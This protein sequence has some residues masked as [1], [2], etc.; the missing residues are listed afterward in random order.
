MAGL[1]R[2]SRNM[3]C[4]ICGGDSWCFKPAD[5]PHAIVCMRYAMGG[6]A[7][8]AGWTA[9]GQPGPNG[10]QTFFESDAAAQHAPEPPEARLKRERMAEAK[11]QQAID[12]ARRLAKRL[13]KD[14]GSFNHPRAVAYIEARGVQ[15]ADLLERSLPASIMF[16]PECYRVQHIETADGKPGV[17]KT[18]APA[19][20]CV[21]RNADGKVQAVQRI[22]LHP[23]E[24]KKADGEAAKSSL[25]SKTGIGVRLCPVKTSGTLV[26][27]EGVE[28][29]LALAAALKGTA[30][31]W[32]C[33][34]GPSLQNAALP[35][36]A[37]DI[38]KRLVIAGDTDATKGGRTPPGEQYARIAA[39]QLIAKWPHMQVSIALPRHEQFPD[40]VDAEQ[41]PIGAKSAD[42]LDVY[43]KHGAQAVRDAVLGGGVNVSTPRGDSPPSP[44]F[45]HSHENDDG[46]EGGGGLPGPGGE[47]SHL[48]DGQARQLLEARFSPH[49]KGA[50]RANQCWRLAR[51]NG[52]W[53]AYSD[54]EA[55]YGHWAPVDEEL[56]RVEARETLS[57]FRRWKRDKLVDFDCKP[58]E[59]TNV[60][61][62]AIR[63][64]HVPKMR[65]QDAATMPCWLQPSHNERGKP[66]W[67]PS[68][69]FG[70]ETQADEI[71]SHSVIAFRNGILDVD[72]WVNGEVRLLP[73][74]P[75]WFTRCVLPIELDLDILA[76]CERDK[77]EEH[78]VSHVIADLCP[79]WLDFLMQAGN[80]DEAWMEAAE[81][82]C[83]YCMVPDVR[84][85]K[86]LWAQ[87]N[88]GTGKTTFTEALVQMLG[89]PNTVQ[90]DIDA[91]GT[92]FDLASF[93]GKLAAFIPEVHVGAMTN[94]SAALTRIKTISGGGRISIEEK[95]QNKQ[96]NVV[97]STRLI[98]TPNEEPQLRDD[99]AALARRLVVLPFRCKPA[100]PNERLPELLSQEAE[101]LGRTIMSLYALR[102]L[103][104]AV[105]AGQA[106]FPD[107]EGSKDIVD[108]IKIA[109]SD[110]LSF[111]QDQCVVGEKQSCT[112]DVLYKVWKA[113]QSDVGAREISRNVLSR[114]L[115][116][117]VEKF[118]SVQAT[119]GDRE[120][121][122]HGL[123]PR[124]LPHIER[125]Q[126]MR[127]D[128]LHGVDMPESGSAE[129]SEIPFT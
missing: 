122:W 80:G 69:R 106:A 76:R 25:G 45:S 93:V 6:C 58:R 27:C 42:W 7:K 121:W 73:P 102:R 46:D 117:G 116:A 29:G 124:M 59:A 40:L 4:P 2:C 36:D 67:K 85:H 16:D 72:A 86:M 20:V 68:L 23:T 44:H 112:P 128:A 84:L 114:R 38:V 90:T 119:D 115:R 30:G 88:P 81:R 5:K 14:Q 39:N 111:V 3:L 37:A 98:I 71:P 8:P 99:S 101:R 97:L 91:L 77:T 43:V 61:E 64:T 125:G 62:A 32:A 1:Q 113:W 47:L 83:G 105:A 107:A 35:E 24:P 109:G 52:Q 126:I 34:D 54:E 120:T 56:V 103:R 11:R 75:R 108:A 22:Y 31:V 118:K 100:R 26:L 12:S 123:R 28:T 48:P 79:H 21:A 60:L 13:S 89:E 53:W 18:K 70:A 104:L 87:G 127:V 51:M 65:D 10:G 95:H 50:E 74:S 9:I 129:G 78:Y 19:L 92:R 17:L 82:W 33:I 55:R 66:T 49:G 15:V 94:T 63:Y 96:G 57:Q 41:K 110:V